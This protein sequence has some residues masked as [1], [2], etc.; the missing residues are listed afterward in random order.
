MG[1]LADKVQRW[2]QCNWEVMRT[3]DL[4]GVV[5]ASLLLL[6]LF[7]LN[8]IDGLFLSMI[9]SKHTWFTMPNVNDPRDINLVN[10]ISFS[11]L[12][13]R[14]LKKNQWKWIFLFLQ[15]QFFSFVRMKNGI[16]SYFSHLPTIH[17][18]SSSINSFDWTANQMQID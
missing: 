15:I 3:N 11:A 4:F 18:G 1:P 5:G 2:Q 10:K 6:F 16:F 14:H 7:F 12:Y 13:A 8:N 9:Q 17:F